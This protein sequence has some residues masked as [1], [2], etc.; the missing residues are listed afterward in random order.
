VIDL[1]GI[2]NQLRV[3]RDL[4]QNAMDKLASLAD[5]RTR[6]PERPKAHARDGTTRAAGQGTE[7]PTL[8]RPNGTVNS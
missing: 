5:T 3:E 1:D 4:I 7:E 8:I 6:G 2:L